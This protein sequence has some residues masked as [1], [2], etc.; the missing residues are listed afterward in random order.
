[1][2]TKT[3]R[4]CSRHFGNVPI[5]YAG[6]DSTGYNKAV[7]RNSSSDGM[8]F[9][10]NSPIQ[11]SVDLYIKVQEQQSRSIEPVP[12]EA[13]RAKV[14]WCSELAGSRMPNYGAGVQYIAKSHFLYGTNILNSHFL[15]D[16]CDHRI[17][18]RLIHRT[19][20]GLILCQD[21]LD[22]IEKLPSSMVKSVERF[23][24]GNV[25]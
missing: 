20:T 22:Y 15:C 13:F 7:M 8:Y 21:C 4:K 17:N 18:D 9:E 3:R 24:L 16:Y 10:S 11:P 1:M 14:K 5:L 19:D 23:L 2:M 25:V 12:Y 6:Y